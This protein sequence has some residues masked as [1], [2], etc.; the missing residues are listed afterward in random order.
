MHGVKKYL[1]KHKLCKTVGN[2]RRR[3]NTQNNTKPPNTQNRKEA[4]KTRKQTGREY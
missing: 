1:K 3:N 2:N 4:Y